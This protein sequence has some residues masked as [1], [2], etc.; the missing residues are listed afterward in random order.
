MYSNGVAAKVDYLSSYE[1]NY[2]FL[3]S[4]HEQFYHLQL[5][6]IYI[7][8]GSKQNDE[9]NQHLSSAHFLIAMQLDQDNPEKV[10][11]AF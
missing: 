2:Q 6:L 9:S 5:N 11:E 1:Q 3:E 4:D 7:P 10:K 8:D